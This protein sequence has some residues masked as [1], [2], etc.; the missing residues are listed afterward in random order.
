MLVASPPSHFSRM[1]KV[2]PSNFRKTLSKKTGVIF[3]KDYWQRGKEN[4]QHRSGDHIDLW[5]KDQITGGGMLMRS[6][7]EFFG[8]VSDFN[9]CKEIWFWEVK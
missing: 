7:Y 3:F 2:D 4:F 9:D 1:I 8:A 5:N 6:I